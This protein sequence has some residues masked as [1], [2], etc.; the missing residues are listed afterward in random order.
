MRERAQA[1]VVVLEQVGVDRPDEDAE[2]GGVR[3][4]L[5][6]VVDQV[7]RDVQRDPRGDA[8]ERVDLRG[9]LELL[10]RVAG[11]AG[12]AEDLEPGAGVAERPGGQLDGLRGQRVE[13]AGAKVGH[14]EDL[15][16]RSDETFH[17]DWCRP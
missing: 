8:G 16:L 13:G 1:V 14:G 7:P 6:V 2:V 11:D 3:G 4:E 9:V 17:F 5:V 12:L 15:V 10:E